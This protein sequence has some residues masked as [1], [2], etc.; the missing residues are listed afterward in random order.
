M[1]KD[2][3][4]KGFD[5]KNTFLVGVLILI[6]EGVLNG[7]ILWKVP[8]TEIDWKA[9][10][11]EVEGYLN[12]STNYYDLKGDTGPL[13]YP[14][15]FVYLFSGLYYL[16]GSGLNIALAQKIFALFY[17][18][19]LAVVFKLY[20]IVSSQLKMP[21]VYLLLISL[22]GYRMHS[23]FALRLFNDGPAMTLFYLAIIAFTYKKWRIGSILYSLSVSIKMNT[24][25][26]APAI[27]IVFL[28]NLNIYDVILNL[29]ICAFVQVLI[30]IEFL[31]TFPVAYLHRSFNLGRQFEFKWTVNWRFLGEKL[32]L[33]RRLHVL[34]LVIHLFLLM[35][36][37]KRHWIRKPASFLS[38][39]WETLSESGKKEAQMTSLEIVETIFVS[40]F[41]GIICARSLHYQFYVW[42]YHQIP[43]LVHRAR[44][45][46]LVAILVM[47]GIEY[48]WNI[49]PSTVF[50]STLL[51]II[52]FFILFKLYFQ[53]KHK[54]Q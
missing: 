25:L 16:T 22:T 7:A 2:L 54:V 50:S 43:L 32:F 10:M 37:F 5:H 21:P 30:G 28:R 1:I 46:M 39:V 33:D 27:L 17:L 31:T 11:S 53:S 23:I 6:A 47:L 40:N 14:A 18:V 24:L 51:L 13:V 45:N 4:N 19:H 34:F 44:L 41:I 38:A 29:F 48:C 35:C 15:G 8:Y 49:Y 9:Y 52:H 3:I 12:G 26:A 36:F 42:Y 20:L